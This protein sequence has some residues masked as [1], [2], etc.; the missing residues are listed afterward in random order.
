MLDPHQNQHYSG[1]RPTKTIKAKYNAKRTSSER[2]ADWIVAH[3]GS[4]KFLAVNLVFFFAWIYLNTIPLSFFEPFDPYPYLHLTTVVSLEA[5]ILSIFVLISQ[6]RANKIDDLREEVD[7]QVDMITE[8][9]LTKLLQL[10]KTLLEKQGIDVSED[11]EL[12]Q[13]LKPVSENRIEKSLEKQM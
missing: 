6:N 11:K 3:V 9:R 5:I 12:E 4:S 7:L 2:A 13:M 1:F 8:A 10:V